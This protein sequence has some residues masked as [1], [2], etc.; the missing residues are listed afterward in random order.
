VQRLATFFDFTRL[1]GQ[2]HAGFQQLALWHT[3]FCT[4]SSL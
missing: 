3:A 2:S 1:Y 4:S